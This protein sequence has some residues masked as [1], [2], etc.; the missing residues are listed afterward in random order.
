MKH[1]GRR[2]LALLTSGAAALSMASVMPLSAGAED[3]VRGK[4]RKVIGGEKL[5]ENIEEGGEYF[6]YRT[7]SDGQHYYTVLEDHDYPRSCS[8]Y[9]EFHLSLPNAWTVDTAAER[10]GQ[11]V[12]ERAGHPEYEYKK[13][14]L[15]GTVNNTKTNF[16]FGIY[17][18]NR[19][20]DFYGIIADLYDYLPQLGFE[21]NGF[22]YS[23]EYGIANNFE[24]GGWGGYSDLGAETVAQVNAY[25]QSIDSALSLSEDNTKVVRK[26]GENSYEDNRYYPELAEKFG[27]WPGGARTCAYTPFSTAGWYSAAKKAG[28]ISDAA[29]QEVRSAYQV[30]DYCAS[31]ELNLTD[32]ALKALAEK[33][34]VPAPAEGQPLDSSLVAEALNTGFAAK[35]LANP[36]RWEATGGSGYIYKVQLNSMNKGIKDAAARLIAYIKQYGTADFTIRAEKVYPASTPDQIGTWKRISGLHDYYAAKGTALSP[37]K[38]YYYDEESGKMVEISHAGNPGMSLTLAAEA[39]GDPGEQAGHVTALATQF[40]GAG[41]K[42]DSKPIYMMA[43]GIST[44]DPVIS[45]C[46]YEITIPKMR[47]GLQETAEKM[48][49]EL[50]A[51]GS[52]VTDCMYYPEFGWVNGVLPGGYTYNAAQAAA[53]EQYLAEKAPDFR[54][55]VDEAQT[56]MQIVSKT[57]ANADKPAAVYAKVFEA[58]GYWPD[59]LAIEDGCSHGL[60]TD[61]KKAINAGVRRCDWS[62]S[63]DGADSYTNYKFFTASEGNQTEPYPREYYP[64]ETYTSGSYLYSF[65]TYPGN[66]A[67]RLTESPF[68]SN[69]FEARNPDVNA[70]CDQYLDSAYEHWIG[71]RLCVIQFSAA[72]VKEADI[73]AFKNAL[74]E[75]GKLA[76]FYDPGNVASVNISFL[77]DKKTLSYHE[78]GTGIVQPE[79]ETIKEW[80]AV[81]RPDCTYETGVI[82]T[83]MHYGRTDSTYFQ[84]KS[85]TEM[86]EQQLM[87]L[88]CDLYRLTGLWPETD[89]IMTNDPVYAFRNSSYPPAAEAG[90]GEPCEWLSTYI[91]ENG[92]EPGWSDHTKFDAKGMFGSAETY[93]YTFE[94]S[95]TMTVFDPLCLTVGCYSAALNCTNETLERLIQARV[96]SYFRVSIQPSGL[97]LIQDYARNCLTLPE[98]EVQSIFNALTKD[99]LISAFFRPGDVAAV[100]H[101]GLASRDALLYNADRMYNGGEVLQA[102]QNW[103]EANR[104]GYT[105][106]VVTDT[107]LSDGEAYIKV[108]PKEKISDAELFALAADLF[109]VTG[110][111]PEFSYMLPNVPEYAVRND[112][113]V[114]RGDMN[115]DGKL[116]VSDAVMTARY[117]AEDKELVVYDNGIRNADVNGSGNVDTDDLTMMLRAIAKQIK[118]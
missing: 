15:H 65:M 94:D 58:L 117:I 105:A 26:N 81:Y 73:L 92:F 97:I 8:T 72:A 7:G 13:Q 82:D 54:L 103:L 90:K 11:I 16:Y 39:K 18:P 17:D 107:A 47:K 112:R 41:C 29:V 34:G 46:T 85:K 113:F 23:A 3:F 56:T 75:T 24:P 98:E 59:S 22:A 87:D 106:E 21:I 6:Y 35:I 12:T 67:F 78:A 111:H 116:D 9:A 32:A 44:I 63:E 14:D 31:F 27:I 61:L 89:Q 74:A 100:R 52:T 84:V 70:L 77:P 110:E 64:S 5:I 43:D 10:L 38:Q 96:P 33:I 60:G 2:I 66:L 76:A 71:D 19:D 55:A 69:P 101:Y 1:T 79:I 88:A 40:F 42:I 68:R 57:A 118:L 50:A 102:M 93:I 28:E 30:P 53:I 99:G 95:A 114:T 37:D 48:Y 20:D 80:L 108:T 51:G 49:R 25:L 62:A 115:A 83:S 109:K 45:A 4:P 91:G 104:P 86:T 36:E